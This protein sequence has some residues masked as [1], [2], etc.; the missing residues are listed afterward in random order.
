MAQKNLIHIHPSL[1]YLGRCLSLVSYNSSNIIIHGASIHKKDNIKFLDWV[2]KFIISD[3]VNDKLRIKIF[4]FKKKIL[5][6][7]LLNI[8]S[9]KISKVNQA[10]AK[11]IILDSICRRKTG[12]LYYEYPF[13]RHIIK[14]FFG[15]YFRILTSYYKSIIDITN[16]NNIIISHP[17]YI[18]YGSLLIAST[19]SKINVIVISGAFHNS[20]FIKSKFKTYHFAMFLKYIYKRYNFKKENYNIGEAKNSIIND[21]K[22]KI[23]RP[24]KSYF[25]DTLIISTHCFSDNN[26]I[27]DTKMMLFET[28]Y[29][30]FKET[31]KLL[32]KIKVPTYKNYVIKIHPYI[33]IYK[34]EKLVFNTIKKYLK[35]KNINLFICKENESISEVLNQK[36]ISLVNIT[37]HGQ[38]CAELGSIGVPTIACGLAQG[39]IETQFNPK[40]FKEYEQLIF[41]NKFATECLYQLPS[42]TK[43]R[44]E[45]MLYQKFSKFIFPKKSL[46]DKLYKIRDY[47][48][49][50]NNNVP[51]R[52]VLK[53]LIEL[54]NENKPKKLI[55]KNGW[56]VF[57]SEEK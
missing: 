26:H 27:S 36:E 56:G 14:T 45:S 25:A 24:S 8:F 6:R 12:F 52:S 55:L 47:Y 31:C 38:I 44:N 32:N 5:F 33:K 13:L 7:I 4:N 43:I 17:V 57:Y 28:Y 42:S 2:S 50:K 10:Y 46:K 9:F 34:E 40:N 39:P 48:N 18:E 35:N 37:V 15:F 41:N 1:S 23:K 29:E 53:T 19:E 22:I 54:K 30:W 51:D 3:K 11:D 16:P 20:Y 49:F 21:K